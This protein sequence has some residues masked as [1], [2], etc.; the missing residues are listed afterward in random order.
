LPD[1]V[2]PASLRIGAL[3]DEIPYKSIADLLRQNAARFDDRLAVKFRKQGEWVTLSY[4]QFYQR[5]L[6][7]ARG[8]RKLHI[9]PGD[10]VAILSENRAGWIIADMGILCAAAVTVPVYPTNTPEQ[11]EHALNHSGAKLVFISGR[12]QY[13]KLLKI[14]DAIPQVQLVVSFERFL[15]ES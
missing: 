5:A 7:V 11:I 8:L 12:G 4:A 6:M 3:M 13:R 15:G 10:K 9:L 1:T 2:L 14:R